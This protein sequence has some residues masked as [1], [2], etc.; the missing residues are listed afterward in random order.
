[1]CH[2]LLAPI[3][4]YQPCT[5]FFPKAVAGFHKYFLALTVKITRPLKSLFWNAKVHIHPLHEKTKTE[6]NQLAQVHEA[7]WPLAQEDTVETSGDL[8]TRPSDRIS[9]AD[10]THGS[11]CAFLIKKIWNQEMLETGSLPTFVTFPPLLWAS[12][13]LKSFLSLYKYCK[14]E[15]TTECKTMLTLSD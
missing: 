9:D 3:I 12:N 10:G 14:L 7:I 2:S 15:P 1:M 11:N 6:V 8:S 4:G 5:F 13:N